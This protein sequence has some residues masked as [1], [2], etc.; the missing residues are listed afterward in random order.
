M[1]FEAFGDDEAMD[2][3]AGFNVRGDALEADSVVDDLFELEQIREL[4][5]RRSRRE[6]L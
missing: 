3:A 4:Q 6:Q 2:E 5:I 1:M